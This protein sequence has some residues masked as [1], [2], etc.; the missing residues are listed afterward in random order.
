MLDDDDNIYVA[1]NER[2]SVAVVTDEGRA[3]EL[4]RNPAGGDR[5]RNAGPLEF[6]TSPVLVGRKLC[7]T[8]SDGARRDNFPAAPGE[9]PKINCVG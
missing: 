2:N 4:Y 5:L 1:P 7:M 9:G 6:P 3:V 8:N